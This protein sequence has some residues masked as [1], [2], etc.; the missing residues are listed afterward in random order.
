[1]SICCVGNSIVQGGEVMVNCGLGG[2]TVAMELWGVCGEQYRV[3]R[4]GMVN[5]GLGGVT[6]GMECWGEGRVV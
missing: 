4:E 3:G 1:M 2:V 5:C 6:V